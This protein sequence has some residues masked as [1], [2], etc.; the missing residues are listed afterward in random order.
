M[1]TGIV[2]KLGRIAELDLTEKWGRIA[3]EASGWDRPVEPGE[4][5][6]TQ[7][8]CLTVTAVTGDRLRF[9]V[10]RETF[11]RTN[12]GAKRVGDALNL[13]RSLRWGDS[14]GGHIVIGHVDGTGV[15]ERVTPVG[16]DWTYRFT[17]PPEL[18]SGMVFKGS[19]AIDGVS[20][21]IAALDE[22]GFSVHIIPFTYEHTTFGALRAGDR[23]NLEVDLL[24][25][26]VRRLVETGRWGQG[27][28]WENLRREG[29]IGE[30][31]ARGETA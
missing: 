31:P 26:F 9:D 18:M 14:M 5:I 16:R 15:V 27:V 20:L 12:L 4:S 28:T 10:L 30:I 3:V 8:I 11:E 13:E 29:L 24:G 1:F 6:A 19:V 17:C 21:T 22:Q 7:G 25:K 23:V 2:Q